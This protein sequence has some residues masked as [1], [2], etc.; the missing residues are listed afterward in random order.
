MIDQ[1]DSMCFA[2]GKKN[3]I[4]LKLEFKKESDCYCTV[5][6]PREEH[7]GYPGLIHGG[8]TAAILDEVCARSVFVEGIMAFTASLNIRY[9]KGIPIGKPVTF[10]SRV[11]KKRGRMH[12]IEARAVLEDGS[13]AAEASAKIMEALHQ[14]VPIS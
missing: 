14:E 3:P 7:Q 6:V 4:G 2:C 5:F 1:Y 11:V 9:R 10:S 8:I 12:E 13:V